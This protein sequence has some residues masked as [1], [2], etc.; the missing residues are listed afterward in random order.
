MHNAQSEPV[1]QS[2]GESVSQSVSEPVLSSL[3]I[4]VHPLRVVYEPFIERSYML[5]VLVCALVECSSS[6]R[7]PPASPKCN[8]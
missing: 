3:V 1:G 4:H 5:V 2:V 7:A 8:Y 6:A